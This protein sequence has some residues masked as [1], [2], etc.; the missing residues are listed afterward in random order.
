MRGL[1]LL[2]AALALGA[3]A[4][5]GRADGPV[6]AADVR[7]AVERSLP[8]LEREGVAWKE[9]Y[10]CLS[11]HHVPFLL[12]SHNEARARGFT[13]DRKK[14]AGWTDWA[15]DRSLSQR[16]LFK[17]TEQSLAALPCPALPDATR[18][19]LKP[20]INQEFV[21]EK[22]LLHRLGKVLTPEELS[23]HQAALVKA[24]AQP[25]AGGKNDGG[26][27]DTLGQLLLGRGRHAS[28]PQWAEF[29]DT[30]PALLVQWQEAN[31]SWQA[32]GQLP[33]RHWPRPVA[34]QA[35]TMWLVLALAS[36]EKPDPVVTQSM[37]KALAH[38][39]QARPAQ[40]N[41]WLVVRLLTELRFG[42]ATR[43]AALRKELQERQNPD[44]GWGWLPGGKSDAFST[45]QSLYAL[46]LAKVGGDAAVVQRAQKY[47]LGTQTA[48]GSWVGA[49]ESVSA[50]ANA[51]RLKRLAP[52]HRYWATAWATIA[53]VRTL[54]Q[55][56]PE[57]G[58][59]AGR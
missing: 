24:A 29:L 58:P 10:N 51:D 1:R 7:K 56:V 53:L 44:G 46:G 59:H 55:P 35:T 6:P 41:E 27:L 16:G 50:G 32:A 13:I 11:C 31:G 14:L 34:D 33:L 18:A 25:R 54:P 39:K 20:V 47:L 17:L 15:L 40:H 23:Q 28:G 9:K 38:L 19:K 4:Q 42:D 26:G 22:A 12:W 37:E 21:T 30:A 52:I 57:K 3:T 48:D 8:Y 36:V 43:A 5:A 49:P 2:I 45:G